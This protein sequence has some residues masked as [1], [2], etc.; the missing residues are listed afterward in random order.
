M[1]K[2][3]VL[4]TT[5]GTYPFHEGGVST[6]CNILMKKLDMIDY[7]LYS[8]VSNPFLIQKFELP[9]STFNNSTI[10]GHRRTK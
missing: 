3:K 4:L 5:E 2:L 10:M 9:I 8:V 1:K 6:W 7:H